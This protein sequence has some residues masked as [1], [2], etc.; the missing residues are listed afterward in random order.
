MQAKRDNANWKKA[1]MDDVLSMQTGIMGY[2]GSIHYHAAPCIDAYL[3]SLKNTNMANGPLL[4]AICEHI[5]KEIHRNYRL[6]ANNYVAL[7]ELEGTTTYANKYTDD[8][9]AK[10]DAYIEQQLAKITLP[11]KDEV[12]LRQRLL[13]MYA[14]PTRNYIKANA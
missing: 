7:D 1:P 3:D 2:K 5:D 4:D 11:G 6:Y 12:Y 13:E 8:D 10:F 14:N 9:K